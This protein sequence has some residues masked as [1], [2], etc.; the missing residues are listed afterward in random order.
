METKTYVAD[1]A[2]IGE[3]DREKEAINQ[4]ANDC[5]LP[6]S[7]SVEI[8]SGVDNQSFT[9]SPK[10][11]SPARS[12]S[13]I[14]CALAGGAALLAIAFSRSNKRERKTDDSESD[15]STAAL[16]A[17]AT[18]RTHRSDHAVPVCSESRFASIMNWAG[19]FATRF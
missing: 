4:G 16:D 1:L 6:Q 8:D 10:H 17:V 11:G 18:D 15:S 2:C 3:E 13:A 9:Q 7:E 12:S 5:E 14:A 19:E